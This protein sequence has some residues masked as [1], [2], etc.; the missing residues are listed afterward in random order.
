MFTI[1]IEGAFMTLARI[2]ILVSAMLLLSAC[3]LGSPQDTLPPL[4]GNY[5]IGKP[6]QISGQWYHPHHNPEYDEVGIASWY[7]PGFHGNTTA[8]GEIYDQN[9]LTAAHPT[10]PMPVLVRVTNLENG[11]SLVLRVND[12]GPFVGGRIIDVSRR[13]AERLGFWRQGTAWV[14]VKYLSG[15]PDSQPATQ[16]TQATESP[17]PSQR[18]LFVQADSLRAYENAATLRD[19]LHG[20]GNARIDEIVTNDESVYRIRL[21]PW[22]D[23]DSAYD[24]LQMV[25]SRGHSR[26]QIISVEERILGGAGLFTSQ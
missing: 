12:R 7:G 24:V 18:Q 2:N 14:R 19:T 1:D 20:F 8:N 23:W 10:L 4:S 25:L 5:K 16:K 15:G 22:E 17:D 3:S 21:G 26:A 11:R 13:A 6:Y 9:A